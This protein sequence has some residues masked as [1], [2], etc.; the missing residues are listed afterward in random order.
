[1]TRH[2]VHLRRTERIEIHRLCDRPGQ[3]VVLGFAI[4]VWDVVRVNVSYPGALFTLG[5]ALELP[6][7]HRDKH[8]RNVDGPR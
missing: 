7:L 3:R 2:H 8:T 6:R 1:M 5:R 4:A